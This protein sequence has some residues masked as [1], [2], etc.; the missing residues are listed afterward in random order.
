MKKPLVTKT[1]RRIAFWN[2]GVMFGLYLTFSIFTLFILNYVLIDDLD[3]RL[4]HELKH[5][6][7]T[8][9]VYNDTIRIIHPTE[10]HEIDL[11]E[12]TDDPFFLQIYDLE[13][14]LFF[15]S[16]NLKDYKEILLGFPNKFTPYYYDNF[17]IDD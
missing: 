16:E 2:A 13:G 14:K 4:R 7:N 15:Q 10:L 6:L 12:V 11:L 1:I 5:I 9:E 3:T 8:I 17:F